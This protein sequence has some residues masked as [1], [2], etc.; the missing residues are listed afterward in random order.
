MA[1]GRQAGAVLVRLCADRIFLAEPKPGKA[2]GLQASCSVDWAGPAFWAP[3]DGLVEK[4]PDGS[5]EAL[6]EA[7]AAAGFASRSVWLLIPDRLAKFKSVRLPYM[8]ARDWQQGVRDAGFW[9]T[10]EGSS[11][12][13]QTHRITACHLASNKRADETVLLRA[14]LAERTARTLQNWLLQAQLYPQRLVPDSL[15]LAVFLHPSEERAILTVTD[16][17][18]MLLAGRP[19]N[20]VSLAVDISDFDRILLATAL[21]SGVIDG[22]FWAGLGSRLA[23]ALDQTLLYL[24]EEYHLPPP[25]SMLLS[26][27]GRVEAALGELLEAGGWQGSGKLVS[28]SRAGEAEKPARWPDAS[29]LAP[30]AGLACLPAAWG[31]INFTDQA[32][33]LAIN[34]RRARIARRLWQ[35]ALLVWVIAACLALAWLP[36]WQGGRGL[37]TQLSATRDHLSQIQARLAVATGQAGQMDRL[38]SITAREKGVSRQTGFLMQLADR[39]PPG[40]ELEAISISA[41][42]EVQLAGHSQTEQAILAFSA[43]L[44]AHGLNESASGDIQPGEDMLAF[45]LS[46]QLPEPR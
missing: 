33:W 8:K 11:D 7:V 43:A 39:L 42:G 34:Q 35:A 5:A 13:A 37:A 46:G 17:W 28:A 1:F 4:M 23:H 12:L 22:D 16:G 20:P 6:A 38:A 26:S 40:L 30:L 18:P 21:D 45:T 24:Q 25:A 32:D 41:G 3:T 19:D 9:Q 44:S 2:G 31:G 14:S 36:S 15:G 29:S 27:S 10:V